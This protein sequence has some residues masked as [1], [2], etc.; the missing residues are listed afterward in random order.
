MPN[1]SARQGI[2]G[3]AY[4]CKKQRFYEEVYSMDDHHY[5]APVDRGLPDHCD[6]AAISAWNVN[7]RAV[8]LAIV[9]R[10]SLV[11]KSARTTAL[12]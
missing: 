11:R 8:M 1:T 12:A 10:A 5:H 4:E 7:A 6:N 2:N 3:K 9:L